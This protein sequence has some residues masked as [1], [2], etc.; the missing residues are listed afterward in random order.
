MSGSSNG[1]APVKRSFPVG[2]RGTVHNISAHL[3]FFCGTTFAQSQDYQK[4]I[5][6]DHQ[7]ASLSYQIYTEEHAQEK[8]KKKDAKDEVVEGTRAPQR[9]RMDNSFIS[10]PPSSPLPIPSSLHSVRAPPTPLAQPSPATLPPGR[11]PA[12]KQSVQQQSTEVQQKQQRPV[13]QKTEK[14]VPPM[15][16]TLSSQTVLVQTG[17]GSDKDCACPV[18]S[19]V[20]FK[21]GTEL[22]LH[23]IRDHDAI[24]RQIDVTVYKGNQELP[25]KPYEFGANC[26]LCNEDTNT[27]TKAFEHSIQHHKAHGMKNTDWTSMVYVIKWSTPGNANK[28][29]TRIRL[30]RQ[31]ID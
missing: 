24:I 2:T 15:Q 4:H 12:N 14:K 13:Q 16:Q 18:C 5:V 27:L 30:K 17:A 6:H 31:V 9:P 23:C 25:P 19:E 7:M 20:R 11:Y 8:K 22:M 26:E 29:L 1:G 3:C 21:N 28:A 10:L